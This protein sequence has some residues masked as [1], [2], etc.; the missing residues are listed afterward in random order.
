MTD[1]N[2]LGSKIA[3]DSDCS[4]D[5]KRRLLLGRKA[6]T[7]PDSILKAETHFIHKDLS[8]QS[9]RFSRSHVQ[10][11][12]LYH[13]E[14]WVPKNWCFWTVVLVKTLENHVDSKEIKPINLKGNQPWIFTGRSDAEAE[15]PILWPPD[16][17]SWLFGKALW[18]WE[19]PRAGEG[20]TDSGT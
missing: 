20:A 2:F 15:A 3:T 18:C 12:E 16:A 6:M 13:K 8:N 10:M 11:G 1:F 17:K 9:Y 4:H 14:R 19:R 5:I 7:N